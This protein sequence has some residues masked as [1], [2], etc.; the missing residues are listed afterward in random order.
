[1]AVAISFALLSFVPVALVGVMAH[2]IA[3][4]MTQSVATFAACS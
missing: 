1:L 4:N 3:I 2:E